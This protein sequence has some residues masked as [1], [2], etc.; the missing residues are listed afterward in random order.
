MSFVGEKLGLLEK[1]VFCAGKVGFRRRKVAFV[2]EKVGFV[3]IKSEIWW[4]GIWVCEEK[5]CVLG[6]EKLSL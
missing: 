3:R 2:G 4:R 1:K 5:K 6:R